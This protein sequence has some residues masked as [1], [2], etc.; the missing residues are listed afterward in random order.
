MLSPGDLAPAQK[1]KEIRKGGTKRV[2]RTDDSSNLWYL[3]TSVTDEVTDKV[4]LLSLRAI[5]A[6]TR[7]VGEEQM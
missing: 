4:S 6:C 2:Q 5:I 1:W 7:R 3:P